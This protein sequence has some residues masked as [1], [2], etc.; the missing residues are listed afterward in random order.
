MGAA[1][2]YPLLAAEVLG[3]RNAPADLARR[4]V[5]Q[6]LVVED[7]R[8][9][10]QRAGERICAAAPT[11]L[12]VYVLRDDE[13]HVLYVG[14]AIDLRRRLRTHFA[15]RRWRGLKAP[16][17]R[18][19][20]AEWEQVGS[21]LEALLR[22]AVLISQLQPVVNVQ[23]GPPQPRG[24]TIPTSLVKN[25]VIVLPSVNPDSAEIVAAH[26]DGRWRLTRMPRSGK[27]ALRHARALMRFFRQVAG[28]APCPPDAD[29]PIGVRLRLAPLAFSWLAV[30]G[31][32][33]SRLD[34]DDCA[35][36]TILAER[37]RRLLADTGL[38]TER[39][40]VR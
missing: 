35:T 32:R 20:E 36:A 5:S 34:P 37:F 7:R 28:A 39:L 40:D 4:L 21:E 23:I 8:E 10:W 11:G 1:P 13:G 18:V 30:R 26:V 3:I 38:F 22:E 14:K 6:A 16:L 12:G 17:A 15:V 25:V 24:R 29:A 31:Q 9:A 19:A 33:A 27:G 2:D